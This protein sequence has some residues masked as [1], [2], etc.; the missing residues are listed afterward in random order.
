MTSYGER[1]VA[2][3][4]L[5]I[6]QYYA[7]NT[8]AQRIC[9]ELYNGTPQESQVKILINALADGTNYG[10]WPWVIAGLKT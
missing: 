2:Y 1:K 6:L 10:N 9:T 3:E 5:G 4:L 7:P 8:E